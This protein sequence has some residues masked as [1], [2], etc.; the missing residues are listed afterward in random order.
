VLDFCFDFDGR[1]I[2]LQQWS[3][4]LG[5]VEAVVAR[6]VVGSCD[7]RTDYIGLD[8]NGHVPPLIYETMIFPEC[9]IYCRTPTRAA[10][11]AAHDQ[12]VASLR[13]PVPEDA[14]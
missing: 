8:V 14:P 13:R 12:A 11:L 10:A 3:A 4:L 7:V 1:P 2:D 9:D 5:S 6:T